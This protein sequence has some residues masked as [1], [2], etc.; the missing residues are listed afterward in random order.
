MNIAVIFAGGV[1]KRMNSKDIPKQFLELFGKPIIIRT[2]EHFEKNAR[3]DAIVIACLEEY[4]EY[5]SGL[6][7]RYDIHKVRR[8]VPGGETGQLSI[9]NGLLAAREVAGKDD[10]VV[11]IHDGV[12]PLITDE[13]ITR[14]IETVGE[15]GNCI[16]SGTVQETIAEVDDEGVVRSVPERKHSRVAKAPQSCRLSEILAVHEQAMKDGVYDSIDTCTLLNAYGKKLHMTD[17]PSEN[18]KITTREDYFLA[19]SILE[20]RENNQLYYPD[21]ERNQQT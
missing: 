10:A 4:T 12:R 14:N 21:E 20:A 17:G 6:L 7:Q 1:G 9:Y 11:M 5:L 13:L 15:Y 19:R 18:I 3:T 2:L 16:T 8:I